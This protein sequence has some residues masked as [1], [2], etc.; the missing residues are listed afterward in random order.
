MV[1]STHTRLSSRS[2]LGKRKARGHVVRSYKRRRFTRGRKTSQFT[3]QSASGGGLGYRARRMRPR[4]YRSLLYR[5][6][7]F[8]THYRSLDGGTGSIASDVDQR[9]ARVY[10]TSA[11]RD[12]AANV[13]YAVAGG[14]VNPNST[15]AV[16][17]FDSP[18]IVRG[19]KVG[20]TM[21]NKTESAITAYQPLRVIVFLVA[22]GD[23]Y[24]IAGVPTGT[25]QGW[26]PSYIGDFSKNIGRVIWRKSYLLKDQEVVQ[27]ERRLRVMK[28]DASTF[29][30]DKRSLIWMIS[31]NNPDTTDARNIQFS[32]YYNLSF[33]APSP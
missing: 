12:G 10:V 14:A 30:Q 31:V 20:F 25:F 2:V 33:S 19:G 32:H 18:I 4:Q 8:T 15:V 9:F 27:V 11:L 22:T 7:A 1:R 3:S 23:E 29:E 28:I 17:N 24:N 13:F 21:V 5:D 6:T 26:D 16:P